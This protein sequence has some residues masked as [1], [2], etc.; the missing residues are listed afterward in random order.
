ML[1][2]VTLTS[3][4]PTA[5]TVAV[6]SRAPPDQITAEART[7]YRAFSG[8]AGTSEP[9]QRP[10]TKQVRE[11]TAA[12]R[13]PDGRATAAPS[14]SARRSAGSAVDRR[15]MRAVAGLRSG[16]SAPSS[17]GSAAFVGG[18]VTG[19]LPATPGQPQ[20]DVC[21]CLVRVLTQPRQRL[22]G[23]PTVCRENEHV[24]PMRV[25][26]CGVEC[27]LCGRARVDRHPANVGAM[28]DDVGQPSTRRWVGSVVDDQHLELTGGEGLL[29]QAGEI[30]RPSVRDAR[31][32]HA[33]A[34]WHA[35]H[36]ARRGR[37]L[38][39]PHALRSGTCLQ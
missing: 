37:W 2:R 22:P 28:R 8:R 14:S 32:E 17:T 20:T 24:L 25:R 11:V 23:D 5:L 26:Q 18:S 12:A 3:S 10:S 31:D 36:C 9:L 34:E 15:W 27:L 39:R 21:G 4:A 6:T 30:E 16:S 35:P 7:A 13:T 33:R 1:A 38:C 29:V 19:L